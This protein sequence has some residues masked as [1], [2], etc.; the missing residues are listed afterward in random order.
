M[1]RARYR[2]GALCIWAA[3]GCS[4]TPIELPATYRFYYSAYEPKIAGRRSDN[5]SFNVSQIAD[6][7]TDPHWLGTLGGLPVVTEDFPTWIR[8]G[9]A[10]TPGY[11]DGAADLSLDVTILKAYIHQLT[12]EKSVNI[13][14]RIKFLANGIEIRQKF[15]RGDDSSVNWANG[16]VETWSSFD[17]AFAKTIHDV[18]KDLSS[19]C[20]ER[21][22]VS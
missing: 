10:R 4:S 15:Y 2:I 14:T 13:V 6:L 9:L 8:S 3:A 1:G 5:C 12:T 17:R 7:R 21:K 19:I 20:S 16:I 11:R 18:D 22:V